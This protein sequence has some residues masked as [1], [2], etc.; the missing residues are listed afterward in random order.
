MHFVI[1]AFIALICLITAILFTEVFPKWFKVILG[2]I[3]GAT[4]GYAIAILIRKIAEWT[5]AF[6]KPELWTTTGICI[7][8][9]LVII[10]VV[11]M[12]I[13]KKKKA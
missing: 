6:A 3:G 10:V 5:K 7:A 2:L 1:C 9:M 11:V 4:S 8:V 12:I 13:K